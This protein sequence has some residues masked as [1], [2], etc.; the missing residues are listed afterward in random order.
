M[1]KI[2]SHSNRS[3]YILHA[4]RK[5]RIKYTKLAGKGTNDRRLVNMYMLSVPSVDVSI[6]YF[7]KIKRTSYLGKL[8]DLSLEFFYNMCSF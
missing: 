2:N 3:R 6:R 1:I 8:P 7:N 4:F 5:T